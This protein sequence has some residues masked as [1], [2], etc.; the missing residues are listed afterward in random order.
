M[1]TTQGAGKILLRGHDNAR[2]EWR[3]LAGYHHLRKLFA[4][5]GTAT[6][7]TA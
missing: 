4:Y 1:K 2:A 3:L 5:S 6:L 7:A